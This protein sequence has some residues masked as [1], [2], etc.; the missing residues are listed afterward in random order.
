M[1]LNLGRT[2]GV[3]SR[4]RGTNETFGQRVLDIGIAFWNFRRSGQVAVFCPLESLF[5]WGRLV[6]L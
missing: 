2:H 6:E 5:F 4:I 3:A 1:L